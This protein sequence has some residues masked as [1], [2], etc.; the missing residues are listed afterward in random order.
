[1]SSSEDPAR[2][3][4]EFFAELQRSDEL[5][6][7]WRRALTYPFICILITLAVLTLMSYIVVPS[8]RSMFFDFNIEL[9]TITIVVLNVAA[10]LI[11][12]AALVLLWILAILA[13]LIFTSRYWISATRRRAILNAIPTLFVSSATV[14]RF[15]SFT[16]DLIE[17]GV[18]HAAA[19]RIAS[20]ASSGNQS[21]RIAWQWA[22]DL[23]THT[24]IPPSQIRR[25]ITSTMA[26]AVQSDLP[27]K[28]QV[29]LLEKS[30]PVYAEHS[31]FCLS[32]TSGVVEP[33]LM[34]MIGVVVG[35]VVL[36][37]FWPLVKLVSPL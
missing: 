20:Y 31:R 34:C 22:N 32:W 30:R 33:I 27:L 8:F 2:A 16:A 29:R 36:S 25:P 5:R 19:I 37:L 26:Y 10:F 15:T 4:K 23:E 21:R 1:M 18:K 3:L 9:P 11:S 6:V 13:I 24:P 28:S 17:A 35:G 12:P 7:Q 14:A